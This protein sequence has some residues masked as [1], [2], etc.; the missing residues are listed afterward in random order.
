MGNGL[1]ISLGG[2]A[3]PPLSVC[4][5]VQP[6]TLVPVLSVFPESDLQPT[7]QLTHSPTH[8]PCRALP[9][10]PVGQVLLSTSKWRLSSANDS[11]VCLSI[12]F[13]FPIPHY[14]RCP[15]LSFVSRPGSVS[16]TADR[17]VASTSREIP[18]AR[19]GL[20]LRSTLMRSGRDGYVGARR[21]DARRCS[22]PSG[23]DA[24]PSRSSD[25]KAAC[26]QHSAPRRGVKIRP[27]LP[28][29]LHHPTARLLHLSVLQ[30]RQRLRHACYLRPAAMAPSQAK[31]TGTAAIGW[32]VE[33]APGKTCREMVAPHRRPR[34]P[35][36][37]ACLD[38]S[39]SGRFRGHRGLV[40]GTRVSHLGRVYK[41]N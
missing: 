13:F 23:V 38:L 33:M 26:L 9:G 7:H 3:C 12:A 6:T 20:T 16:A 27:L 15:L 19:A 8:Q 36:P 31:E 4:L 10:H 24:Q 11:S 35:S 41:W 32:V 28:P 2:L 37:P 25:F 21:T 14:A 40:V 34:A 18:S 17:T 1:T 30:Q 39:S 22:T 29:C 5:A